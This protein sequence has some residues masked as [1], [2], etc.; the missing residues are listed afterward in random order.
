MAG[1]ATPIH[2]IMWFK[3]NEQMDTKSASGP[4]WKERILWLL[5]GAL[6]TALLTVGGPRI[7]DA[8]HE[9]HPDTRIHS[10]V[11]EDGPYIIVYNAGQAIDKIKIDIGVEPYIIESYSVSDEEEVDL[12]LGGYGETHAVF[13]I[14]ELWPDTPHYI[15]ILT[16]SKVKVIGTVKGWSIHTEDIEEEIPVVQVR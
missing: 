5:V 11:T 2:V 16:Q 9:K 7:Y 12:I 15:Q 14:D 13:V 1:A 8:F 3:G 4:I 6:V 10:F